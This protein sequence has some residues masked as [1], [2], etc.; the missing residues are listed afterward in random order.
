MSKL[1]DLCENE[2]VQISGKI[3]EKTQQKQP[4]EGDK[5]ELDKSVDSS[6]VFKDFSTETTYE[7]IEPLPD[8]YN[9]P[10]KLDNTLRWI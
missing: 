2:D 5:I 10:Q 9:A 3:K 1:V 7:D 8:K 6:D 4:E